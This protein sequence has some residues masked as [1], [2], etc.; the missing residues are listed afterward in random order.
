MTPVAMLFTASVLKTRVKF[1][2]DDVYSI[3]Y[4]YYILRSVGVHIGYLPSFR[5][6]LILRH[7]ACRFPLK[8]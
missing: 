3:Y 5:G 6:N 1:G 4:C 8:F 2:M 7:L